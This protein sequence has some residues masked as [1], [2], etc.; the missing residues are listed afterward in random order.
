MHKGGIFGFVFLCFFFSLS[1]GSVESYRNSLFIF[2]SDKGGSSN[3]YVKSGIYDYV[4]TRIT[5]DIGNLYLYSIDVSSRSAS[6]LS[7][8]FSNHESNSVFAKALEYWFENSSDSLLLNWK[9]RC[10]NKCALTDLKKIRPDILPLRYIVISEGV[11][12][13]VAR[14]YIQGSGFVGDISKVLF[15]DTPHEGT[16]F[17]DQTLF[18]G[19]DG[20]SLKKPDVKNLSALIPLTL[21]AYVFGGLDA[22]QDAVMSEAKSAVLGMAQNAGNISTTF[23]ETAL[24]DEYAKNSD[25]LWYLAQD[26]SF[27]DKKYADIIAASK[28][29]VKANIGEI[30]WLNSTGMKTGFSS[31]S[32]GIVYSYGF[33]TVGNGR[34]TYNDFGE[35]VKNHI[36]K[37]KLK[38]VFVDSLKNVL[39]NAGIDGSDV[40]ESISNLA[41]ELLKG[42]LSSEGRKILGE[43]VEKYQSLGNALDD[44]KLFGYIQGLSELRSLKINMD[45]L[46]GSALKILRVL[47]KFIPEAYKSELYSVFIENFSPEIADVLG[48]AAN[49]AVSKG[50]SRNCVLAGLSVSAKNLSNYGL[51]FFDEGIFDVP[52]YSAY[53][54]NVSSFKNASVSRVGYDLGDYIEN[55]SRLKEYKELLANVGRLETV[56]NKLDVGLRVGC[57]LLMSPYDE[58]CKAAAFAANVVLI[59]DMSGKTA[60]LAQNI[61]TLKDNK[62]LSLSAAVKK[63]IVLV[64]TA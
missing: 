3:P 21:S 39:L 57:N 31:P 29:E 47:E 17:A 60:K 20:Y 11:S 10:G 4:S 18:Q 54:L 34:R 56:R 13:L 41:D 40:K 43:F 51:N 7:S 8:I 42:E 28:A 50:A 35:Q 23:S 2:L 59:A 15:F 58:I 6:D 53:G 1:F 45:D 25:A 61:G 33:P 16:G 26:A 38:Q 14:E 30:Q 36:P 46:P 44:S 63:Q 48:S 19:L 12:G 55:N 24:F 52:V 22:L 9:N 64:M 37:E 27:D 62:H 49:C 32:Y 5:G